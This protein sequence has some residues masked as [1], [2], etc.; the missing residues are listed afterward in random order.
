MLVLTL[1]ARLL[2]GCAFHTEAGAKI[3][4]S[5]CFFYL[6]LELNH[7]FLKASHLRKSVSKVIIRYPRGTLSKFRQLA[8]KPP[9]DAEELVDY[10]SINVSDVV[11]SKRF[12][13]MLG[14][15][16]QGLQ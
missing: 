9:A 10:L 11:C 5:V 1:T 16:S 12:Y 4:S 14:F 6:T 15:Q 3:Q 7:Y 8:E 13:E 2:I